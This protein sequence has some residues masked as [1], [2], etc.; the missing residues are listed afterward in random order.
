MHA[1]KFKL[2]NNWYIY[3]VFHIEL[4]SKYSEK[5]DIRLISELSLH[6]KI[7]SCQEYKIDTVLDYK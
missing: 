3:N 6:M 4:L 5:L 1:V 7:D 2:S